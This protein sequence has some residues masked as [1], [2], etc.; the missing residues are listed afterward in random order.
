MPAAT[1]GR[2]TLATAGLLVRASHPLPSLA[3]TALTAVFAVGAGLPPS[4]LVVLLVAVV[5]GQLVIGWTNDLLDAGR[6]RA[7]GRADKPVATGALPVSTVRTA[8]VSAAGVT[9]VASLAYGWLA[10]AVHLVLVVGGGLAYDAGLK[11]TPASFVPYLVAFGALPA[12][13]TLGLAD[14]AWP[15]GWV[16]G[17]AGLLGVGAHLL[18]VLPDLDQDAATGVVGLPHRLGPRWLRVAAAALLAGATALVLLGPAGAPTWFAW[19]GAGVAAVVLTT[20]VRARGRGAFLGAIA[21]AAID[22][23]LLL[24]AW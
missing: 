7:A 12:V 3:V 9:V 21:V 14:P 16:M 1:V 22:L 19:A 10:G 23:A 13:V 6:D 20:S 24:D 2:V 15:P 5:S 11:S 17:A 8:L 4:R 18:N